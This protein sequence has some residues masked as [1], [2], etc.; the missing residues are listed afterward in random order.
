MNPIADLQDTLLVPE[1]DGRFNTIEERSPNT[2]EWFMDDWKTPYFRWRQKGDSGLFWIHGKPGSGKST[3]MKFVAMD[4][5]VEDYLTQQDTTI[6]NIKVRHFFHA[7]GTVL[8]KSF[9][10][11]LKSIL[12]QIFQALPS[13]FDYVKPLLQEKSHPE[14]HSGWTVGELQRCLHLVLSQNDNNIRVF[15]LIDA[16]DEY[17]GGAEFIAKFFKELTDTA[18]ERT[19]V[20]FLVSSR[21]SSDILREVGETPQITLDEYNHV[22]IVRYCQD[23][24]SSLEQ[25]AQNQL[26]GLITEVVDLSQ[27]VFMWAKLVLEG[28]IAAE[29]LEQASELLHSLPPDLSDYYTTIIQNIKRED[30]RDAYL[31]FQFAYIMANPDDSNCQV[32]FMDLI[33]A[34]AI[35]RCRT[36]RECRERLHD[37]NSRVFPSNVGEMALRARTA[38]FTATVG[39]LISLDMYDGWLFEIAADPDIID[40]QI[41]RISNCSGGL[42]QILRP[43]PRSLQ[44]RITNIFPTLEPDEGYDPWTR[45]VQFSHQTVKDFVE[46]EKFKELIL[47]DDADS[48]VE[49][50]Y[51]FL[52]K[53]YLTRGR[54]EL[55]HTYCHLSEETTGHSLV[56][57]IKSMD[58][59]AFE[60]LA[61]IP[62]EYKLLRSTFWCGVMLPSDPLTFA[63]S[64]DLPL[65]LED[66]I[67]KDPGQLKT[68][69][70]SL[71]I[72]WP[73]FT[74]M[75]SNHCRI[76]K[77]IIQEGYTM[78]VSKNEYQDLLWIIA[79]N[80]YTSTMWLGIY[81]PWLGPFANLKAGVLLEMGQDPNVLLHAQRLLPGK[82]VRASSVTWRSMH[83]A[84]TE[85]A[86]ILLRHGADVNLEDG[87]AGNTPLDWMLAHED[88][89]K[90]RKKRG[91]NHGVFPGAE[92]S[93][94]WMQ[95]NIHSKIMFLIRN[96]GTYRTTGLE[97]WQRYIKHL[98]KGMAQARTEEDDAAPEQGPPADPEGA[99]DDLDSYLANQDTN[100]GEETK[101]PTETI[102]SID[103]GPRSPALSDAAFSIDE[104]IFPRGPRRQVSLYQKD[105]EGD[106]EEITRF[107]ES[108]EEASR[109][110]LIQEEV[111]PRRLSKFFH[112]LSVQK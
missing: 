24:L 30:R 46:N 100:P 2:L 108:T 91:L 84:D 49:D 19:C 15:I 5:R 42:I 97:V 44:T 76:I 43:K 39:A 11:M 89:P 13:L 58:K 34:L 33:R 36:Y 8:Q 22:D 47:G 101:S 12:Y 94:S 107:I 106:I 29:D 51:T 69:P 27:G 68:T 83:V 23:R 50:G 3:L 4:S 28:L 71:L 10:G 6:T 63:I 88:S 86:E 80:Q 87:E 37:L 82:R 90:G 73:F 26:E 98:R 66:L 7:R 104:E 65:C 59:K 95:R 79:A 38:G 85:L 16:L 61:E 52:A 93:A 41:K 21:T 31:M 111:K 92:G 96:G 64:Y 32:H 54:S 18:G 55:A 109:A 40:E 78:D 81:H 9:E 1:W 56:N 57:F 103:S 77:R 105:L 60:R 70:H 20:K 75:S 35:S 112:R 110:E 45:C 14:L 62:V 17:D 72:G 53:T 48:M 102:F 74:Q 67:R 99:V 25:D